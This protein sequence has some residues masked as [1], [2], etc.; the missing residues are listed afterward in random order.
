L[1]PLLVLRFS[2]HHYFDARRTYLQA[3]QALALIPEVAGLTPLGHG[4]RTA[5]YA[6]AL[7]ESMLFSPEQVDLV[8]TV[9]RLHH[10]GQIAHPNLPEHAFGPYPEERRLIGDSSGEI[11]SETG[12][13]EHVAPRVA[14]VHCADQDELTD[15]IAIVRVAST[16]DD[17]V[18]QE[19]SGLS[20][21]VVGLLARHDLGIE[22]TVALKLAQLCD[23]RPAV[24]DRAV[25]AGALVAS[26]GADLGVAVSGRR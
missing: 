17:L 24:A 8:A 15:S 18:G 4:E 20:D 9:A 14:A 10:I 6:T 16:L 2:F 3:T 1:V 5:V 19:P 13:L 11:L 12:F 23:T 7:A 21:A 25:A 22:R 26:A